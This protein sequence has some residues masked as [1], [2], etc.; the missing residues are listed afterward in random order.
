VSKAELLLLDEPTAGMSP[1]E[2]HQTAQLLRE[3]S[4]DI[5]VI[6]IEHD[7]RVVM[8]ISDRVTVLHQGIVLA[9]GNPMKIQQNGEVQSVYLGR[10]VE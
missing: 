5:T 2:T 4:K 10:P 9:D 1:E 7:M 8:S 6:L 3:L